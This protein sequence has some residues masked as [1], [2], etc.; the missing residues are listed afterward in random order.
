MASS[1][2]NQGLFGFSRKVRLSIVSVTL[3]DPLIQNPHYRLL[4]V[5]RGVACLMVVLHH[6]GFAVIFESTGATGLESWLRWL[7]VGVLWR[8]NLGVAIFFVISGYC[9]GASVDA[10][11]RRGVG[12]FKF[13]GRRIWRI[14]P[15]YWAA[16]L[17]FIVV[18]A[19]L[20]SVGLR[21]LHDGQ[22]ALQLDSPQVLKT[23]QWV[24]NVTLTEEWRPLVWRPPSGR[25]FTRIAWSLCY[26][27]QFYFVC[28]LALLI[29]PKRLGGL[30]VIITIT[31]FLIRLGM[32]DTGRLH[33]IAGSFFYLWHEFAIGLAVYWRLNVAGP[34][35]LKSAID[36]TLV[37]LVGI[38]LLG[39]V[40]SPV[41]YSLFAASLFGLGLIVMRRWD[42][43]SLTWAWLEPLRACG[44]R[45]YSMYLVHLPI[46]TVGNLWLYE[47]G[48][49][50]FWARVLLMIP[51]V[52]AVAVAGSWVFF[53]GVERHFLNLPIVTRDPSEKGLRAEPLAGEA[54]P[55]HLG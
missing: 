50:G 44:R 1:E 2:G 25:V 27:E 34:P 15:P 23:M 9:I 8:M 29:A 22:H 51:L 43:P 54:Q 7:V 42:E 5:W 24:G 12:A 33:L 31:N 46:C 35:R 47:Q 3:L 32:E 17:W 49:T 19:G 21:R 40:T 53:W 13:L 18:T 55:A 38:G 30:L 45:C 37:V 48:M 16:I 28:F 14:Y 52:S 6:A 36:I 11:R 4:D 26:E 20:D 10:S 39:Y 41:P